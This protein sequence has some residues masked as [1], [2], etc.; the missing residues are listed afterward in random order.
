[1][2]EE[3]EAG[4]TAVNTATELGE[5]SPPVVEVL[6]SSEEPQD[7]EENSL[8]CHLGR[9]ATIRRHDY[10]TLRPGKKLNDNVIN[11]M[12]HCLSRDLDWCHCFSTNL[13]ERFLS[14]VGENQ[15][16]SS[17][18]LGE[19]RH[20]GVSRWTRGINLETK[21][22]VLFPVNW[23]DHWYLIAAT[24]LS[25]SETSITVL[26]SIQSVGN[27]GEA[28]AA[29]KEYL[30]YECNL[31]NFKVHMPQV[32]RQSSMNDCGIFTILY[33]LFLLKNLHNFEVHGP[34]SPPPTY[35]DSF[36]FSSGEERQQHPRELVQPGQGGRGKRMGCC[37]LPNRGWTPPQL[38]APY[39]ECR[40]LRVNISE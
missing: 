1:M 8:Y 12:L 17:M 25:G 10:L 30:Y 7:T 33:A 34:Y 36:C 19:R 39:R 14:T 37:H 9:A 16:D 21:A 15:Q 22:V 11:G 5:A 20:A 28:V 35:F 26:N 32:P 18:S 4:S 29:V 2:A 13:V 27:V 23:E 6:S 38:P 40:R 31:D 24:D 3:Q